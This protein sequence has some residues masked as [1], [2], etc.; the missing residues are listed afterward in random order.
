MGTGTGAYDKY[1]YDGYDSVSLSIP[2]GNNW[3]FGGGYGATT[4]YAGAGNNTFEGS[5]G[6]ATLTASTYVDV[7][8]GSGTVDINENSHVTITG[9]NSSQIYAREYGNST[10]YAAGAATVGLHADDDSRARFTFINSSSQAATLY[11]GA[12]GSVTISG[13]TG[14]GYYVG[15]G[16]GD[17]SLIGGSGVVTLIGVTGGD[18]LQAA[19]NASG[20]NDLVS[21]NGNETM[22]GTTT[23]TSNDFGIQAGAGNDVVSTNGSGA[24]DFFLNATSSGAESTISG[25]TVIG[26]SNVL[27]LYADNT[28]HG[29][30]V[31]NNFITNG[32]N[33][34]W[35]IFLDH[36]TS[37]YASVSA[38][39]YD[40]GYGMVTLSDGV[41]I[42]VVGASSTSSATR[43]DTGTAFGL[44]Y[45]THG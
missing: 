24:Q 20:T 43:L 34:N 1:I 37:S 36:N 17:N 18:T 23:S 30:Y 15:G 2:G 40:P 42:Y 5:S 28:V 7:A 33:N 6:T 32:G 39:N 10:I 29:N 26:A 41:E 12:T 25:S 16:L 31:L 14:G 11:T 19:A 3:D 9:S 21:G 45:I 8:G 27:F 44:Q 13:G 38:I 4:L 35:D 22:I